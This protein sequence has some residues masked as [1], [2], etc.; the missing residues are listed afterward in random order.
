MLAPDGKIY[1]NTDIAS[2]QSTLHVVEHPDLGGMACGYRPYAIDL[3]SVFGDRAH[4]PN[5]PNYRLGR[6]M[7]SYCDTLT[8][9]EPKPGA[10]I[11]SSIKIF[12]NP[13]TNYIR[14][15]YGTL[16]WNSSDEP[17]LSIYDMIGNRVYTQYL[18]AYRGIQDIDISQY[19]R[20]IYMIEI[21]K[22]NR[23]LGVGKFICQP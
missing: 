23:I 3:P 21:R 17:L 20:G 4:F 18:P 1:I 19:S 10:N 8:G 2:V 13:A 5:N 9:I 6:L 11:I 12:P 22:E 7:G 16:E 14:I 15:D